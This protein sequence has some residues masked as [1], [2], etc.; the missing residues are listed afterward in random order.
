MALRKI[1][2]DGEPA[3]R[4]KAKPVNKYDARLAQ[5]IGDMKETLINANGVGLAAPQ[6]G[7]LRRIF[8]VDA[9]GDTGAIELVNPQII[10][11][12]GE[13]VFYEGCL[14]YPGYYGNVGRP[15]KVT[16][17]AF[18]AKGEE[19]VYEASGIYAVAC[20]HEADHLEGEMFMKK[21]RGPLYTLEEVKAMRE[22]DRTAR[23]GTGAVAVTGIGGG[24]GGNCGNSGNGDNGGNGAVGGTE[25]N[26][27]GD[28]NGGTGAGGGT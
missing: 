12:E 8:V 10:G 7:I 6:L 22:K 27:G 17:R 23:T 15:E 9:G 13:Q 4:K 16:L 26:G 2:K 3:L 28:G 21:V 25:V 11:S 24:T 5:L 14:S 1:F 20:C 19:A 18:N